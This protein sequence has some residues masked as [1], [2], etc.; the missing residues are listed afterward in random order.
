MEWNKKKIC[1]FCDFRVKLKRRA[2]GMEQEKI[3]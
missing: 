3:L 1:D 2:H